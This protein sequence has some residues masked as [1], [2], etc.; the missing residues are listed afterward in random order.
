MVECRIKPPICQPPLRP[1]E[2]RHVTI[3]AGFKCYEGVVLCADTQET[4][5]ELSKRNIP[6]LIFEPKTDYGKTKALC[7]EDLA[8]AFCGAANNGPFVDK[9]VQNAW[10]DC[11]T[12]TNLEEVCMQIQTSIELTYKKYNQIY[13]AGYSP[14]AELIYGVKMFGSSKMFS[15]SGPVVTEQTRYITGGGGYY[16]ADFL[17]SRM[18]T[19]HL[20]LRQCAILAAYVLFQAKEHVDGCGGDSHIAVLRNHGVSG[21]VDWVMIESMN[22]L[23]SLS[24]REMSKALL[25][26]ADLEIE[27]RGFLEIIER[28]GKGV[29]D[30]RQM[31]MQDYRQ[32]RSLFETRSLVWDPK[33]DDKANM[34]EFGLP[35]PSDSQ[36]SEDRS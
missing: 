31:Q 24:D 33:Q 13:Q 12:G 10:E 25:A 17:A 19:D 5:A 21:Q 4:V 36:K 15:A 11:Q 30:Y 32:L 28:I 3:V 9:L 1:R 35:M 20:S 27:S 7:D 14:S 6:K 16:M 2:R 8:V 23:L 34:D 22:K 29:D 26:S 18:Y